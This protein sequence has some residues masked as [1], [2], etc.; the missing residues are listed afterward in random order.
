MEQYHT[1]LAD[2]FAQLGLAHQPSDINQFI[3]QH[4]GLAPAV[5]IEQ[6]TFWTRQQ[7]D[8]LKTALNEDS[9][10][11]EVIDQLSLLLH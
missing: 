1:A 10:W 8:F 4:K 2:L 3:D 7:A 5:R 11:A 9:E 6:A